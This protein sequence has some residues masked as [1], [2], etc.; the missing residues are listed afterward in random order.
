MKYED[1]VKHI[2]SHKMPLVGT[3]IFISLTIVNNN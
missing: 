3:A 2:E 1:V